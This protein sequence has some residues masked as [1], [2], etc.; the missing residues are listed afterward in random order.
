MASSPRYDTTVYTSHTFRSEGASGLNVDA[1]LA[2]VK[3]E[4]E[5]RY[6][7]VDRKRA[8]Y[9]EFKKKQEAEAA[10]T[11]ADSSSDSEQVHKP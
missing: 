6:R 2:R 8:I 4:S 5:A 7:Q 1:A 9:Q 10:A 11:E 3:A